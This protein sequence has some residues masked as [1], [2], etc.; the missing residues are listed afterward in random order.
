MEACDIVVFRGGAH[1]VGNYASK[2]VI[3]ALPFMLASVPAAMLF[4]LVGFW[5]KDVF[6]GVERARMRLSPLLN[7]F[8]LCAVLFAAVSVCVGNTLD[9]RTARFDLLLLPATLLGIV[10]SCAVA[11]V[12]VSLR[13]V[14][15]VLAKVGQRSLCLF[16][17]ESPI[18]YVLSRA[19]NGLIPYPTNGCEHSY[20]VGFLRVFVVLALAYAAS[21]PTMWLLGKLRGTDGAAGR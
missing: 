12:C 1:V 3:S 10:V 9:I 18:A 8:F 2:E 15:I 7:I 11:K 14:R 6:F 16:A 13:M 4:F 17:W 19:T 20:F 5:G 21:Y